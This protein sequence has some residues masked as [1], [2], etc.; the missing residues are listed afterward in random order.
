MFPGFG[1]HTSCGDPHAGVFLMLQHVSTKL[2]NTD[3]KS[4]FLEESFEKQIDASSELDGVFACNY[5][6]GRTTAI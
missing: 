2:G 6:K 3:N 5:S 4:K 1:W